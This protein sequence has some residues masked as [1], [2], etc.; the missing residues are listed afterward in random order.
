MGTAELSSYQLTQS[1]YGSPRVGQ[2]VLIYVTEDFLTKEQ[3]KANKKSEASQLVLKLNKTKKFNTGIYPILHYD[4]PFLRG[5]G[6]TKPLAKIT[7][8]VQEWCGQAYSQLNR[9]ENLEIASHSY[10]EGEADEKLSLQEILTE[11]EIW[12]WI[13]TQPDQLPL[14]TLEILPSFE[15]IRL[16]HKPI[17]PYKAEGSLEKNK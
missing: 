13:R 14:G 1:R 5:L 2:A 4:K 15:Y 17:K 8:S 3:V 12:N 7:T 6:Q 9:K 11:D 10:F 16:K